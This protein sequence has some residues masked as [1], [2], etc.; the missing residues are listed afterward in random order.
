[1]KIVHTYQNYWFRLLKILRKYNSLK[2]DGVLKVCIS[3]GSARTQFLLNEN[4]EFW[5][6]I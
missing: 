1:M 5:N 3:K 2:L 4:L 6:K